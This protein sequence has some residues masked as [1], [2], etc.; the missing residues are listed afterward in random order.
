M[1][2]HESQKAPLLIVV[3]GAPASGKTCLAKWLFKSLGIPAIHKD[4]FKETLFDTLGTGNR[5]WSRKL[6]E[7]GWEILF[8]SVEGQLAAGQ[9]IIAEGN[10]YP[11]GFERL[12]KLRDRYG[13]RVVVVNC[14]AAADV[15]LS[16]YIARS[17]SGPRHAG[18]VVDSSEVAR[19]DTMIRSGAFKPVHLDAEIIEVDTTDFKLVDYEAIAECVR[20]C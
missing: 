18:H 8:R 16:R 7:A 4:D 17:R 6:G 12:R 14:T 20:S 13:A 10:F 1:H 2:D 9:P 15:L 5:E 3:S 19:L 11:S